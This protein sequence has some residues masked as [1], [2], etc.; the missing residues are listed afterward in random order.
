MDEQ[1][2]PSGKPAKITAAGRTFIRCPVVTP[3]I[4]AG[5]DLSA[6]LQTS[7]TGRLR[8]GDL[9]FLSEKCVACA[10]GR[11][12]PLEQIKPRPLAVFL[13]KY[14]RKSPYGIGLSMPE[15][16]EVALRECGV[17]R[18]LLA[19]VAGALGRLLRK[20]GWF[21]RIAGRKPAGIDGPCPNTLPPYNRYVVP[22]PLHPQ[23]VCRELAQSLG[24]P[25]AIVDV[26]DF[27]AEILGCSHPQ[28]DQTLLVQP[29]RD[30]PRGQCDEQ[31]PAG[32]LRELLQEPLAG[33]QQA[34]EENLQSNENQYAA[35][36]DAGFAS[37][38]NPH[39]LAQ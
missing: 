14:V 32:I 20:T 9:V 33:L 26:N 25:V 39:G 35:A 24:C 19:S 15:T 17:P 34:L 2:L 7:L 38:T 31:P 37:Q 21:Y 36:Q 4:S 1:L 11:A 22:A 28:W 10:Q 18:I 8:L 16:M 5:D 6:I 13:S 27:G 12:I 23:Q 30:T 29:L 3:V